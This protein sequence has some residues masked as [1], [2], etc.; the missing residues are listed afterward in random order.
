[1]PKLKSTKLSLTQAIQN[2]AEADK[3]DQEITTAM[4]KRTLESVSDSLK[5]LSISPYRPVRSENYGK[6]KESNDLANILADQLHTRILKRVR[7]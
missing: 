1:M 5:E 2:I 4:L 7:R 6:T 3:F